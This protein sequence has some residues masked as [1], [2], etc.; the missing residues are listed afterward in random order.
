MLEFIESLDEKISYPIACRVK[1]TKFVVLFFSKNSGVVLSSSNSGVVLSSSNQDPIKMGYY[2][3]NWLPCT[4]T[5]IWERVKVL[6]T[7]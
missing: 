5:K 6:I 4:N 1:G 3:Q 7:E 2:A